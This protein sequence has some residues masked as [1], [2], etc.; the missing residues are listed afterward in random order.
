MGFHL[1]A[2][3]GQEVPSIVFQL[4]LAGYLNRLTG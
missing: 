3:A 2:L 1:T 4:E